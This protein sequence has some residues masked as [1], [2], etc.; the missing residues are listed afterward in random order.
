MRHYPTNSPHAAGRIVAMA[1]LAD[2]HLSKVEL[3]VLDRLAVHTQLGLA[4]SEL[5]SV[6]HSF[7]EDLLATAHGGWADACKVD[8]HTLF[9]LLAEIDDPALRHKVLQLC[10]SVVDVDG[11][12]ADGETA[13]L[14]AAVAHWGLTPELQQTPPSLA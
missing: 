6:V 11:H 5:H 7:C 10:V 3:D 14:A 9:S 4:R 12:L 2:G 13:L 1:L 8:G